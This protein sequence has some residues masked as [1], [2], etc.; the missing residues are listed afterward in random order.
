MVAGGGTFIND[1]MNYCGFE[2]TFSHLKRYPQISLE[3][4]KKVKAELILLSSEPYP[5][6]RKT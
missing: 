3:I 6:Q 4:L 2:N 1:M 5:F